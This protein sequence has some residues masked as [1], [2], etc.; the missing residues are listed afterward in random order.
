MALFQKKHTIRENRIENHGRWPIRLT[1]FYLVDDYEFP[2]S[3]F[4]EVFLVRSGHFLHETESGTQAVRSGTAI[5]H[6]PSSRHV[7]KQPEQ[8][9]LS[10]V[11]FLP[12][13][14]AGD[15]PTILRAADALSLFFAPAWFQLPQ[16]NRVQV[17]TTRQS[18]QPFLLAL[19]DLLH[20]HLRTGRH[21]EPISR[22]TL[23]ELLLVLGDEYQVY[24]RGGNRLDLPEEVL[25]L[26]E[27]VE[28]SV[29]SGARLP[30]KQLQS[31]SG[32]SQED[33][34][35]V[36]RKH[37]GVPLVDYAQSRRVH[38]A[39]LRLQSI[40]EPVPDTAALFG[41]SDPSQ[42][43]KAF[44]KTLGTLPGPY[45]AKFGPGA[46]STGDPGAAAPPG[47]GAG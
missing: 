5:V 7:V 18:Q 43:E 47:A 20:Q 42:M 37:V 27:T 15:F 26:L 39:A 3:R 46:A 31:D 9:R 1:D 44:E 25:R 45:A 34:N 21:A 36:F 2:P 24:W 4:T 11:R 19:L 32:R 40:P 30:L 38:H 10:R 16:E 14:F 12:E 8:V 23:L 17:F 28:R 33:L 41:F 6:H 29:A 35:Q 22:I 13:S